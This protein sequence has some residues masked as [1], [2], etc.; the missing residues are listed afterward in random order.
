MHKEHQQY[1]DETRGKERDE[2][3]E[4]VKRVG[5]RARDR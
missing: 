1:R 4:K 5:E 2:T 3:K